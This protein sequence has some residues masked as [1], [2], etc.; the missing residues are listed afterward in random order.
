MSPTSESENENPE[1]L[2]GTVLFAQSH[3]IPSK[4]R[5]EGDDTQPHLVAMRKTLVMLKPHN[6]NF[7]EDGLIEMTVYGGDGEV[8]ANP[9]VM[10]FPENIPKHDSWIDLGEGIDFGDIDFPPSLSSPHVIKGQANLNNVGND[11]DAVGL[12]L[13]MNEPNKHEVEIR[14]ADGSWVR[15]IYFPLGSD[16]PQD[17]KIQV[18]CNSGCKV[19]IHYPKADGGWR[20]KTHRRGDAEISILV[21]GMWVT[22][23][24]LVHNECIFGNA[25]YTATLNSEWVKPGMTLQFS[26]FFDVDSEHMGMLDK[27]EIGAPTELM[28]TTLDAGFL[29]EP[30]DQFT[31]KDDLTTHREYFETAPLS[32][33]IVVQC[34]TMHLTEIMLP[35]GTFYTDVSDDNG[36]WHSGDMRQRIGKVLLSHG[37]DLANYGIHSSKGSSES[38]HP[39]TC[40]LLAAHNTVGLYQ[41]GRCVDVF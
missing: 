40:A 10:N 7:P 13:I 19:N 18:T 16:V 21:N 15:H 31:F 4:H 30:R 12:T 6:D 20:S 8:L 27:I 38:S 3:V 37:I 23:K 25:F 39:F 22:E 9:I 28:I 26:A 32:R 35:D 33:L 2:A 14:T 5:N 29:T 41:N 36:G 1:L 11:E 17:S 24:D 34:E